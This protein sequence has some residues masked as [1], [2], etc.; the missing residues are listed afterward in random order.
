MLTTHFRNEPG[1]ELAFCIVEGADSSHEVGSLV[2]LTVW[3][4]AQSSREHLSMVSL[5]S[6]VA[7]SFECNGLA[8]LASEKQVNTC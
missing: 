3:I 1:E 8:E 4:S 5:P 2:A 7:T 6:Q